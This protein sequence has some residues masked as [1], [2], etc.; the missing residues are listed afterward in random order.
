VSK[1]L[2]ILPVI[3]LIL[4]FLCS[5]TPDKNTP[6]PEIPEGVLPEQEMVP[7]LVEMH[8]ADATLNVLNVEKQFNGL[9]PYMYYDNVLDKYGVSREQFD[10]SIKFYAKEPE[11]LDKMYEKVLSSLSRM[12]G[13]LVGEKDDN[14]FGKE[15]N[16][17]MQLEYFIDFEVRTRSYFDH[18]ISTFT[19]YTGTKSLLVTDDQ[20]YSPAIV[21]KITEPVKEIDISANFFIHIN[22]SVGKTYPYINASLERDAK[23]LTCEWIYI[24]KFL[25]G[26]PWTKIDVNTKLKFPDNIEDADLKFYIV[27]PGKCKFFI[28][29]LNVKIDVH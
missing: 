5:C 4:A 23:V 15:I 29:E 2:S 28:D 16:G 19:A 9:K 1:Q 24:N 21:H 11:Y 14:P 10:K 22:D 6:P 25:K 18:H 17:P 8:L 27:N 3:I 20:P 26:K 12:E 7:V 13:N